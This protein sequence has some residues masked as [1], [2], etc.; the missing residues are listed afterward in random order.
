MLSHP[1]A[2]LPRLGCMGPVVQFYTKIGPSPI[3]FRRISNAA[4]KSMKMRK[5]PGGLGKLEQLE[6]PPSL[7]SAPLAA[8]PPRADTRGSRASCNPSSTVLP[9]DKPP[10]T[11]PEQKTRLGLC[12]S[13]KVG[14]VVVPSHRE[15]T[16]TTRQK[17]DRLIPQLDCDTALALQAPA[18]CQRSAAQMAASATA[19]LS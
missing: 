1:R 18:P 10:Q 2:S 11:V 16:R 13:E 8:T 7:R 3:R 14:L 12:H 17:P 5:Q 9:R 6:I 4:E 19:V 15:V